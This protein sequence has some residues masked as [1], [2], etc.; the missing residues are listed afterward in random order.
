MN[1]ATRSLTSTSGARALIACL[2]AAAIRR[3]YGII[4][5]SNVEF[6]DALYD[7]RDSIRYIT[8]R[9]EQVATSMADTEARLTGKPGVCLVHSGPGALNAM[10]GAAAAYKDCSPLIIIAGAVRTALRGADGMLE[11]DQCRVFEPVCKAVYR[12]ENVASIPQI[13]SNAYRIAMTPARGPVLIEVPDN[14]WVTEGEADL[15]FLDLTPPPPKPADPA[16][17]R[18]VFTLFKNSKRVLALA[19]AGVADADAVGDLRLLAEDYNVPVATT[20]NG[21]G[22]LPETHPLCLGRAGFAGGNPVADAGMEQADLILALGCCL[23]DLT[24]YEFTAQF[25]GKVVVVNAAE[26]ALASLPKSYRVDLLSLNADA[27]DFLDKF[28][29]LLAAE[30]VGRPADWMDSLLPVKEEWEAQLAAAASSDKTPLSPGRVLKILSDIAPEDT[31]FVGG[32]GLNAVYFCDFIR[33]QTPRGYIAPNNFG[34]MGFGFGASL[35]AKIVKPD[36]PVICVIGDGDFMMTVQDIETGVREGIVVAVVILNDNSYRA[37][38]YIQ[39]LLHDRRIY[40]TEYNNPDF[41]KLAESFGAAGFLIETPDQIEPVL[42]RAL[43]CGKL[44]IVD[45]RV[46]VEDVVPTNMRAILKMRGLA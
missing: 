14:L 20:G 21:R 38:R 5:T 19:G 4:G 6:V 26:N 44:A 41:V 32:A 22:V 8:T 37:L 17:V 45:A 43:S 10:L 13:F 24:T 27:G 30:S 39:S 25:P 2:E 42:K 35:A 7:K 29:K 18:Q 12:L 36:R 16:A 33:V 40:G 28:L 34:A 23:S 15:D 3:I 1:K 11:L 31:V 9:H 46:D